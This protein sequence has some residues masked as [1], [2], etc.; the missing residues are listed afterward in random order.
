MNTQFVFLSISNCWRPS[1]L[2]PELAATEREGDQV[3]A[4][5]STLHRWNLREWK[6]L[7]STILRNTSNIIKHHQ[8]SSNIIK[9]HQTS[10]NIFKHHRKQPCFV[11]EMLL[12]LS[13]LRKDAKAS[14]CWLQ[15]FCATHKLN[16]VVSGRQ[17]PPCG[18][19]YD[20]ASRLIRTVWQ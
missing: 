11:S 19:A 9:H 5:Q 2:L 8:A 6:V 20:P 4:R 17:I 3:K 16:V 7:E 15:A 18:F 1:D 10:S 14:S 13:R 12:L